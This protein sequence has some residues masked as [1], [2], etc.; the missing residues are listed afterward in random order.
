MS[1]TFFIVGAVIFAT[2]MYFTV[3][4]IY[5]PQTKP[6]RKDYS[7][8]GSEGCESPEHIGVDMPQ[9]K[10]TQKLELEDEDEE[11]FHSL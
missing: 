8:L 9:P 7:N 3:W 10:S 4:N 2:Y 6:K 1:I 11:D 5:N